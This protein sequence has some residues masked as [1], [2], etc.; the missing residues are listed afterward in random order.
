MDEKE[1]PAPEGFKLEITGYSGG[2]PMLDSNDDDTALDRMIK[3]NEVQ[4]EMKSKKHKI[5]KDKNDDKKA[6]NAKEAKENLN[7]LKKDKKDKKNK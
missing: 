5:Q 1:T 2:A 4:I 7:K 6:K 3:K